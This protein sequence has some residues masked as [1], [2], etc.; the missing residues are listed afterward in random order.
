[1]FLKKEHDSNVIWFCRVTSDDAEIPLPDSTVSSCADEVQTDINMEFHMPKET[2]DSEPEIATQMHAEEQQES[3]NDYEQSLIGNNS[4]HDEKLDKFV[5]NSSQE[6]LSNDDSLSIEDQLDNNPENC[7]NQSMD[8]F[9]DRDT[10]DETVAA[11]DATP[12][13]DMFL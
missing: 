13:V 11:E 12:A 5:K 8:S 2:Q 3:K 7:D 1:M 6:V 4:V 9:L 10:P